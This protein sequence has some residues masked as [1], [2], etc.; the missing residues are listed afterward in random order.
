M[1]A[2]SPVSATRHLRHGP[3]CAGLWRLNAAAAAR[4]R[5]EYGARA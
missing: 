1:T 2:A 4:H 5:I 3:V